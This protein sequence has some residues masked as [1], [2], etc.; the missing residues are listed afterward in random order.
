LRTNAAPPPPPPPSVDSDYDSEEEEALDPSLKEV[1][2]AAQSENAR[3]IVDL[4]VRLCRSKSAETKNLEATF[5]TLRQEVKALPIHLGHALMEQVRDALVVHA[6][7]LEKVLIAEL[8][9]MCQ[10]T[11]NYSEREEVCNQ[12][13]ISEIQAHSELAKKADTITAIKAEI[14]QLQYSLDIE[15]AKLESAR[16]SEVAE[17]AAL[18]RNLDRF[19]Q[20]ETECRTNTELLAHSSVQST[21]VAMGASK[22][23]DS[24]ESMAPLYNKM[25]V[26]RGGLERKNGELQK[27]TTAFT[28]VDK[29]IDTVRSLHVKNKWLRARSRMKLVEG[30]APSGQ[31]E[32]EVSRLQLSIKHCQRVLNELE[33]NYFLFYGLQIGAKSQRTNQDQRFDTDAGVM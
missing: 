24:R 11:S 7:D 28:L 5:M 25:T 3:R 12:L 10:L 4:L 14:Q 21:M 1:R 22:W 19:G 17:Q 15:I 27:A 9:H 20:L 31:A 32:K 6:V 30:H 23:R 26:L 33:E 8:R 16:R 2:S 18:L 13:K 29:R